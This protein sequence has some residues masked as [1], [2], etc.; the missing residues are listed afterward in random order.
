MKN[1][2]TLL[3][4]STLVLA[5]TLNVASAQ[6]GWFA[7]PSP[8]NQY[9]NSVRFYDIY[10]GFIAGGPGGF[11][12]YGLI[13][14]TTDGG[15]SWDMDTVG[16]GGFNGSC[17]IGNNLGWVV[18]NSGVIYKTTDSGNNWISQSSGISYYL[19]SV[20]FIDSNTGWAVGN[21]GTIL[22]TTNGGLN[23]ISQ[24]SGSSNPLFSVHFV[25]V[26]TGW[27]VGNGSAILKTTNGGTNWVSQTNG[28]NS[29]L[30][31]VQFLDNNTGWIAGTGILIKTTN[32]GTNWSAPLNLGF[33]R[34]IQFTD[35]NNGWAV[36]Y[37]GNGI[38]YNTTNG[39]SSW[40]NQPNGANLL[41]SVFFI[42]N[43]I[44]WAVGYLGT[45]IKTTTGGT[46][47]LST[48]VMSLSLG[49]KGTQVFS[50]TTTSPIGL[51]KNNAQT[52]AT[53]NVTRRINPGGYV[54]TKT[55][56]DLSGGQASNVIFD[57]WT[58]TPGM[59]YSIK[60]SVYL[61]GDLDNLNDTLS[62]VITPY[63]GASVAKL[64]E[65]FYSQ[66]FPP[67]GWSIEFTGTN[68]WSRNS[69]SSYGI[70]NGSAKF[71]FWN[72][73]N[74]T[75]QSLVTPVFQSSVSGD[76]LEFDN[77]YTPYTDPSYTDSLIIETSTNGGSNYTA[78]V[79]LWGNINGGT[80]N[81]MG[82]S[83][84]EFTAPQPNQWASRKYSLPIGTNKIKFRAR[85]GFGNH[86][87]L[88]SIK[89]VTKVIYTAYNIKVIPE[90]FYNTGTSTLNMKDTVRAYLHN[91]FPPYS[92]AD[93]AA[94]VFD[95]VSFNCNFIFANAPTGNYYI[96]IKHRNSIETWSKSG[97]E[98]FTAGL[99]QNYDFTSAASQA[100]GNNMKQ[101]TASPVT[102][103]VYNG[104]VNQNGSIDL[105]DVTLIYNDAVNFA[106]GYI[107]TDVNGDNS[108]DLTD[109]M[110]TYN[111]SNN[112]VSVVKP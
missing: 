3:A 106:T 101:I 64:S 21:L 79:R 58:F 56:S 5:L 108:S 66:T 35:N 90:G 86:L 43:N 105:T 70:G 7:Q 99:I 93:S 89:L 19:T 1:K 28:T 71:D 94:G 31:S 15:N 48:D 8:T 76:S 51:V 52:Q 63:I 32:G 30:R 26:N 97:G 75:I 84:V 77:A 74:G 61:P 85:S 68:Y 87:Y 18:G 41:F 54:S 2:F 33:F 42:N 55:I 92:I 49:Q 24:T 9:L 6:T 110:I 46:G 23:W 50:S 81:S 65:G 34:S 25:D 100:F 98:I 102:F 80:L 57:S 67:A 111:N 83:G 53:F 109:I 47:F 60:D 44:G 82:A 4:I 103:A 14:K 73:N 69:V 22:K 107:A 40:T 88:D 29:E 104:D 112:F 10:K 13:L 45:I 62:G 96:V 17:I 39:G 20:F 27:T 38:I 72:S 11:N 16:T 59:T 12:D 95:S 91:N 37:Y 36:G 78:L